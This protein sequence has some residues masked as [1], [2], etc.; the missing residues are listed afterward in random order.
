MSVDELR[1]ESRQELVAFLRELQSDFA[2]NGKTWE[3]QDLEAFL[4]ALA[5]WAAVMDRSYANSGE[6]ADDKTP[7]RVIADSLLAARIY[8]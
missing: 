3:N 1:V 8:E 2:T 6:R 7:W 4:D 5:S